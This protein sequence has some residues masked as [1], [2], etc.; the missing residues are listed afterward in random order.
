MEKS[1]QASTIKPF[2]RWPGGKRWLI[3]K[4]QSVIYN[5]KFDRYIEPFLGGGA[6]FF[7]IKHESAVLSDINFDLINSYIQIR[8]SPLLLQKKLSSINIDASTYYNIRKD[9]PVDLMD[10]AVRFIYLNRTSFSGLYRVNRKGEFN[11]PYGGGSR[12]LAPLW[13]GN[14][15]TKAS[16]VLQ[17]TTLLTQSF[18]QSL[19]DATKGDLIYCD[20]TYTVAHNDNGFQRYNE[21]IFSWRDQEIL[22][23]CANQAMR[24]GATVIISN[25]HHPSILPLYRNF[26][27]IT[28]ERRS[29]L[30]PSPTNRC[31]TKEYLFCS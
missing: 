16:T 19:L 31:L 29:N 18:E 9:K 12:T 30:C 13:R 22:A 3:P 10:R 23:D 1:S 11:V 8:D 24:K 26:E 20:P 28:V 4:I 7:S 15:I 17:G 21:S 14:L 2:L 25:A 6:I 27:A 5:K